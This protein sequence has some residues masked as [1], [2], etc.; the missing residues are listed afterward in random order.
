MQMQNGYW[1]DF[2]RADKST[3][4]P[5]QFALSVSELIGQNSVVIDVGCGDGRDSQYFL[6]KGH[7]VVALDGSESAIQQ[8]LKRLS[9]TTQNF[10]A[11]RQL[12]GENETPLRNLVSGLYKT[13]VDISSKPVVVYC[14]FFIHAIDDY[15]EK[16]FLDWIK[17]ATVETNIESL[18][19]EYRTTLDRNTKKTHGEHFRRYVDSVEF[20]KRLNDYGFRVDV[21]AQGTGLAV[22]GDEDPHICRQQAWPA[23]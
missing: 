18:F 13:E 11:G 23:N 22:F 5:S 8:T 1:N 14:R 19:F 16:R 2:Y 9:P 17:L 3:R 10:S 15:T 12:F 20:T 7:D 21:L 6:E 4:G